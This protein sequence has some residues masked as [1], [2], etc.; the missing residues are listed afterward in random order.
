MS[1]VAFIRMYSECPSSAY[2]ERR[3][4][5][6][7]LTLLKGE[8]RNTMK[9]TTANNIPSK[10]ERNKLIGKVEPCIKTKPNQK[11]DMTDLQNERR[12]YLFTINR[13][14][15]NKMKYPITVKSD[16]APNTQNRIR[17]FR[18]ASQI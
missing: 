5:S 7:I 10:K 18:L 9:P 14:G 6:F 16:L 4:L 15:V 11:E 17:T 3:T 13:V 2:P 12:D 8:L 1:N